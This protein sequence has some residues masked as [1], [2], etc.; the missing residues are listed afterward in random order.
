VA[1]TVPA[2]WCA[3]FR[4]APRERT[5]GKAPAGPGPRRHVLVIATML[6]SVPTSMRG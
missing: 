3:L 4:G 5:G 1:S 2:D 6:T